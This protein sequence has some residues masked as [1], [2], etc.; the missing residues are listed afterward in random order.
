MTY[1]ATDSIHKVVKVFTN[2][3]LAIMFWQLH[4]HSQ[5]HTAHPAILQMLTQQFCKC[6]LVKA[7][8]KMW[9]GRIPYL[10]QANHFMQ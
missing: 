4:T 9:H 1:H 8:C 3:N 2:L 6:C 10:A 7:Y 5:T